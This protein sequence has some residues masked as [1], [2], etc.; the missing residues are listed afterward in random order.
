MVEFWLG[1]EP[2]KV[3]EGRVGKF[4][5]MEVVDGDEREEG[6]GKEVGE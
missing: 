6:E 2:V 4:G 1:E 5:C 3:N